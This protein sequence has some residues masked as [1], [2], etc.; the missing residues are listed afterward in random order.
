MT[1]LETNPFWHDILILL[2]EHDL[3]N[4]KIKVMQR[5]KIGMLLAAA[6]AYGAYKYSRLSPDQKSDLKRKGGDFL[7]KNLGGVSNLFKKKATM[8]GNGY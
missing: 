3:I 5:S 1:G 7:N 8:N 4:L 6:A 2:A